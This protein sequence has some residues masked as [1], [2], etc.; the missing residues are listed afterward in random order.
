MKKRQSK[1][2]NYI[3]KI[4]GIVLVLVVMSSIGTLAVSIQV[5]DVKIE[6]QNGYELTALTTNHKVS[7]ILAENN[8]ILKEDEKVTPDLDEE[9]TPGTTIK[10]TNKSKKEVQIANVSEKGVETSIDQLL[11]NYAPITE[12]IIVE[13]EPIPFETVTKNTTNST[14]D[15]T[16]KVLQEGEDGIKQSTY[17]VKYQ[18]EEEIEKTLLKEEV[19]KEPKNRIVQVNKKVTARA[20]TTARVA[21][22]STTVIGGT[23]YKITAYCSCAK[24]CGKA[25]GRTAS[26]THATAGRTV[27]APGNF[28]FGTKLNIGGKIYVVED[29]GGAIQGNRI[30]IYVNSHEAALQWGVRYL[31]VSVVQ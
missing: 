14:E 31:P 27:A 21:N 2:T 19:I 23:T 25:T 6:L 29:R 11:E 13:Q 17:K 10:I 8:I 4:L 22:T 5:E 20:T 16:S 9:V 12:K 28:A 24:C 7:D 30:D 3:R 15:T 26:G 1:T 18:N